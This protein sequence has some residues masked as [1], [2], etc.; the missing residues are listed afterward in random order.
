MVKKLLSLCISL[1]F[2]VTLMGGAA[3]FGAAASFN[4]YPFLYKG[5]R[6]L[7]MGSTYTAVGRDAEALFYNPATLYDMGFQLHIFDPVAEI[8]SGVTDMA[9][10]VLDAMD[11]DTEKER[12][13][14]LFD[15]IDRHQGEPL[16]V[17]ISFF[18]HAA[19]RNFAVGVL[20]QGR[21]DIK[22]HSPL[23]SAGAVEFHGGYEYGPVAGFSIELPVPGLRVGA[24]AK[25]IARSWFNKNFTIADIASESFDFDKEKIDKSDIS[26]DLGVLYNLPLP[27]IQK[28]KPQVGLSVLDI[29]DLDFG[30]GGRIP[31]RVNLGISIQPKVPLASSCILALD[32]Q[33][34]SKAFEQDDSFGKRLHAG[35]ELGFLKNHFILRGGLNGGYPAF[36]AEVDIW[37]LKVSYANYTE[38]IGV[39]AGQDEDKRQALQLIMGW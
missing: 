15:I 30:D 6:S 17:R 34:I 5:L 33:D 28:I 39:Y 14:A 25:Y 35:A 21:A 18:P 31:Q 8:D 11:L 3:A 7:G 36:G 23:S 13:D 29:T 9:Q 32:Y 38:E 19:V 24:G 16:H 1:L 20:G 2:I 12:S 27:V 4:D 22:L 37:L 26:L 10:D